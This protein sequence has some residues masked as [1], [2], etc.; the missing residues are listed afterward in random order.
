M[1]TTAPATSQHPRTVLVVDD[2]PNNVALIRMALEDSDLAITVAT[3][4][5]GAEAIDVVRA[6][7]PALVFMD[8]KMPVLDGW[9]ATRRLK[10]DPVTAGIPVIALTAQ[11]MR[12]DRERALATGCDG[13]L[14]KPIDVR[15]FIAL[16]RERMR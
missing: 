11:A 9:E 15:Q 1:D 6:S 5:N 8:L 3:A 14:T 10:A 12:G 16:V 7:H 4:R 13:Y 2:E